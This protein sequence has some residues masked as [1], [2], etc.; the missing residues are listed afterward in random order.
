MGDGFADL[1]HVHVVG[2]DAAVG[3][4]HPMVCLRLHFGCAE[5]LPA[6]RARLV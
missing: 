2:R 3:L 5:A 6:T 4:T 1:A